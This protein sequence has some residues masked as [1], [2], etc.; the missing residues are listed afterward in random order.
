MIGGV[1]AQAH[2]GSD[3]NA[4]WRWAFLVVL[5]LAVGSAGLSFL[6]QDSSAPEG[7]SLDWPGQVTI[8]IAVFTLLFAVI[9]DPPAAGGAAR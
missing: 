7:R 2:Y 9:R 1:A 5:V 6:A 8:A 4:G 3:V